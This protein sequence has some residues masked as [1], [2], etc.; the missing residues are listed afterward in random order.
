MGTFAWYTGEMNI[1]EE[2][3]D[4]FAK[5]MI[6]LLNYGGMMG[7][8]KVSLYG[9]DLYL[10]SPAELSQKGEAEFWYNYFEDSGWEKA[11]VTN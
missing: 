10:L 11:A 8:E 4:C 2:K 9:Y 6:K 1:E 5:Q 3:R 7:F